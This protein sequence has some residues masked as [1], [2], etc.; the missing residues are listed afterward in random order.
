MALK[1]K[2]GIAEK[3]NALQNIQC[4]PVCKS[5]ELARVYPDVFCCDCDWDS[6]SY[7]VN[8]GAMNNLLYAAR[9]QGFVFENENDKHLRNNNIYPIKNL[10]IEADPIEIHNNIFL[11]AGGEK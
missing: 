4:C 1:K 10:D 2:N 8:I 7:F 6:T 9:I 3:L 11:K 5:S